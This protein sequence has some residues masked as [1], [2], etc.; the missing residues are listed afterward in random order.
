MV[1]QQGSE[2]V[3]GSEVVG[4]R[5]RLII[6]HINFQEPKSCIITSFLLISHIHHNSFMW[7]SL[8]KKLSK[9]IIRNL[10]MDLGDEIYGH[11]ECTM[12][13]QK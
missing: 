4:Q 10:E 6:T 9:L 12:K 11:A 3:Q 2:W 13:F 5:S 7:F 8:E 1:T